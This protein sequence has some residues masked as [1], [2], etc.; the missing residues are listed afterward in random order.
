MKDFIVLRAIR[1]SMAEAHERA[2][3]LG[4]NDGIIVV[5]AKTLPTETTEPLET[6]SVFEEVTIW[7]ERNE[8]KRK[9]LDDF[10]RS[11]HLLILNDKNVPTMGWG[12]TNV[13][14]GQVIFKDVENGRDYSI[15]I[16]VIGGTTDDS[17]ALLGIAI[18][19]IQ[20]TDILQC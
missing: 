15:A 7:G 6:D 14:I 18:D 19:H 11:S 1:S 12:S 5:E 13:A 10:V 4:I 17:K 8:K 2:L 16:G 3:E 20:I 9:F